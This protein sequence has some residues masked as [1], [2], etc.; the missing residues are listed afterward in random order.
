MWRVQNRVT[1]PLSVVFCRGI[2]LVEKNRCVCSERKQWILCSG[3]PARS[4]WDG[5]VSFVQGSNGGWP[6]K[7]HTFEFLCFSL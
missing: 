4:R 5:E 3:N 6:W 2:V 1:L 7:L